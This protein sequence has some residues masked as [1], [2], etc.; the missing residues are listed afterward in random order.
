MTIKKKEINMIRN[1]MREFPHKSVTQ[2]QIILFLNCLKRNKKYK[3][4]NRKKEIKN[5]LDPLAVKINW[6]VGMSVG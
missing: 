6:G 5:M 2:I 1:E 3:E 4:T